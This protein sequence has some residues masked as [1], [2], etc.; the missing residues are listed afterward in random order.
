MLYIDKSRI[1][2]SRAVNEDYTEIVEFAKIVYNSTPLIFFTGVSNGSS[3]P[4]DVVTAKT[5]MFAKKVSAAVTP[6]EFVYC[7]ERT[8]AY[9]KSLRAED[10]KAIKEELNTTLSIKSMGFESERGI[11]RKDDMQTNLLN[12]GAL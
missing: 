7:T 3:V 6:V 11:Y 2:T 10:I 12:K 8:Y 5:S 1:D 9:L 4:R